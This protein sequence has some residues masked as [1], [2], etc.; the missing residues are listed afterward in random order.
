MP[1]PCRSPARRTS[2]PR[3]ARFVPHICE[4]SVTSSVQTQPEHHVSWR[5][6][7]R[8]EL[9]LATPARIG[10]FKRGRRTV[11]MLSGD[12]DGTSFDVMAD[13]VTALRHRRAGLPKME[14]VVD[15]RGVK[16]MDSRG[17][18][19]LVELARTLL[20]DG[21]QVCLT[22]VGPNLNLLFA[23]AASDGWFPPGLSRG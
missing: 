5:P 13:A 3:F 19:A 18:T 7:V 12:F 2:P 23:F 6:A 9:P 8:R 20:D 11:L 17:L 21:H 4:C 16:F 14:V 1:H 22:R 15:M 10:R